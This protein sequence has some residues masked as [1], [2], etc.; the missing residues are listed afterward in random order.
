[1]I[2]LTIDELK[3]G[4]IVAR[5]VMGGDQG[6]RLAAGYML[7]APVIARCRRAGIRSLW[8]HLEGEE[9][10]P[11]GNVNDTLA[12]QAQQT[13][14]ENA[15][16]LHKVGDCKSATFESL[17]E[18]V[19][20]GSRFKNIIAT[21]EIKAVV[22]NIIRSIL[23]QEPLVLNLASI[24][25]KDGYL[26]QHA[27]DTT[28]TAVML[29]Q[30]L[31]FPAKDIQEMALGCFLMDLGMIIVPNAV[32]DKPVLSVAEQRLLDEHP[33]VGYAIMR[34]N[35]GI[36]INAAHIAYQH[37]EYADGSGLPRRL[38][39]DGEM[40][41][42]VLGE[43]GAKIHR[44]AL[45]AAVADRYNAILS[46]RPGRGEPLSP[47]EAMKVMIA[48]AGVRYNAHVVNALISL[49][50]VFPTG[51]RITLVKSPNKPMLLGAMGVVSKANAVDPEKPQVIMLFDKFRRKMKPV[52]MDLAEEK[53][54]E[55]Q[56][57]PLA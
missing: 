41:K 30:R 4:M 57:A 33:A 8:V 25:T 2:A 3:P 43:T 29:A 23:S 9:V 48:E 56:F 14:K 40:P 18:F 27:L 44:Y 15:E 52:V 19:A 32:F 13:W 10:L 50:P 53:G 38:R 12:M 39:D 28:I 49:I 6:V 55:I 22:E 36:S 54:C 47:I 42:K 34:A 11:D 35:E 21:R 1:M 5:S 20:D 7:E 24:R 46:P 51:T 16:L 37:H 26:H 45:V 17:G 31:K